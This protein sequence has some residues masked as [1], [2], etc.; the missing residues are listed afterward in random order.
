MNGSASRIRSAPRLIDFFARFPRRPVDR[1]ICQMKSRI[2]VLA[3]GGGSN[4]QAILEHFERLGERRG[5]DVVLVASDRTD[6]GALERAA[7]R[8]IAHSA[9]S[10][11]KNTAEPALRELLADHDVTLIVL[12]GYTRLVPADIVAKY[13]GKII[14]VHPSLLPAFGGTGM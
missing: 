8:A 5:G 6:A 7:R 10:T 12:A 9:H 3:S 2:A 11:S 4:L 1:K 13:E 14:N